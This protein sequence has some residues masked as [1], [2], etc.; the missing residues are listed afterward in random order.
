MEREHRPH[1]SGTGEGLKKLQQIFIKLRGLWLY[2]G[3]RLGL[4]TSTY[5]EASYIA[6]VAITLSH[7]H[8]SSHKQLG[9]QMTVS[10]KLYEH[11]NVN[12]L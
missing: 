11:C 5:S 3:T 2:F 9:K 1:L 7:W 6:S 8:E 4:P 10:L 12:F